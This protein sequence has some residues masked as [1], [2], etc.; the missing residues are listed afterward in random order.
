MWTI[1]EF[2]TLWD[3]HGMTLVISLVVGLLF[4]VLGPAATA[5]S[6]ARIRHERVTKIKDSLINIV[7]GM[8]VNQEQITAEK[9]SRMFRA[10]EREVGVVVGSDYDLEMLVEDVALRFQ[11]SQHLEATQK[12]NYLKILLELADS[13]VAT[14]GKGTRP[15]PRTYKAILD[16]LL[17]MIPEDSAKNRATE[18]LAEEL[19]DSLSRLSAEQSM[20]ALTWTRYAAMARR[21]RVLFI[22]IF[23]IYMAIVFFVFFM[24]P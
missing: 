2:A 16:E 10:T 15:M 7:E 1:S 13:Q 14:P 24:L 4:F 17:P 21:H 9:L 5:F 19:G 12:D 20:S 11:R 18:L 22:L 8:L 6:R 23:I 3:E